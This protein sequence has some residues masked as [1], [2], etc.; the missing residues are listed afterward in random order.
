MPNLLPVARA[1]IRLV[2]PRQSEPQPPKRPS[3]RQIAALAAQLR[4]LQTLVASIQAAVQEFGPPRR[5]A[6]PVKPPADLTPREREVL[7]TFLERL[8]VSNTARQLATSANTV[9]NQLNAIQRKLHVDS[10][11]ELVARYG[12]QK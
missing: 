1:R 9:R 4:A 6:P 12:A 3:R 2:K 5:L 7:S 8:S 10:R 11:V